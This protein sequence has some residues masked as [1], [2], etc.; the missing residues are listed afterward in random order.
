MTMRR[1]RACATPANQLLCLFAHLWTS[2]NPSFAGVLQR[3]ELIEDRLADD[4]AVETC[5]LRWRPLWIT[6]MLTPYQLYACH[7][8]FEPSS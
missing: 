6:A 2:A 4:I 5:M 3:I 1:R 7:H 8:M